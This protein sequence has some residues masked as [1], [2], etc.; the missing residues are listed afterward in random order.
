MTDRPRRKSDAARRANQVIRG[1]TMLIM[2]LLGVASF[3]VLF[4]KLYDLQI[5]RHDELKAEAVGQQTDSMVISASRGTIYDKN[6]EIMAI[7]YSTETVLLDPGGVQDFVESQ[8]QKIQDAAEEAAEKGAPYTAPE[9]LDQAYIARGL[10]RILDVEEETILEHLENTA[11]R[12]WEVKKKV[13][14]DVADEVRRFINGEIDDEGNQ[15]TTVDEDGNTVLISTGGRPT[16]LQGISLTP[17]TKRLYP[18]G[19]LAGNVIGFVNANNMGAYGLEASYDDVLSG[20]TGLTITP[21]N[22]NGTPL[23]FSGGEQMF[24]AENGSSLVLTL[25]T[26]VQYALEKGLES[27]LDKYD[28]ANGGTGIVM[29]VNTGGIVAMASYPNYDP[30]DFSTIY[31]EG[32]QAE[33]DAAL[34]EIQQNRSTYETEEAYNQALANARATIQFKQ[35][36]NKCYQDTYEPGST[37]KPI[38]LATALEEGVVNMNTTFTCTGS[39]HVEGWGKAINCSK[40]AGHGTQTLKVATG[41][42]CNPAFVTMGLK[43]GTEAY[44]RY[45]KSFGLMETTGIDLPAEA[46]GIFANEDSFNSNVV[47]LAAYSFGQTFNVTPLELIRAQAATING[48]Y[49]YTPYLVEQVLDDEG[50]ILSQH[51]TTAVRQVISEETSAKVRECLEWV[52][53]DGGGRNGQVTGYR[54]GGKTGTADKTGT[55]DVVVSFMCFAPADDPQYIMLLTM[56]TPSRTTGTAVFGGTMVAPVASQIMSEILPLLGVEPDY[57]AEE[58]VGADTTVPNVVGQTREAAEDRLADLGFTFRTVGDGDTV[59]DQTP[60][61]GAIV[62]GNASIILY[63]GQEKPDTPCTVPNVVGKSAS[64]ANKAIT[65]AGLIMKVTGTTT[66]SSGNVYAITQ[67]LPAGTEVAAGTVVTV[68]FGDN[69]V[70]D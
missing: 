49:L 47:S 21:T 62:P 64:E 23:L 42:S 28:A 1:R 15:L 44:Y 2:L 40:R 56:D 17:D 70:L 34:A 65:N 4:W 37:F 66:A 14:Q 16:R 13:D 58:L 5:N 3:T 27:M 8:E 50:N 6:G 68:Q 26:N 9:V 33:L 41:N 57:T 46:E 18:F 10:S 38:T 7:S 59:T 45:L 67:S 32:L 60:A 55:K 54:I 29:D 36:R 25:D 52:V 63:L 30:G 69:S 61:G 20:S 53:S 39:I 11:N 31:T 12:Y 35:W 22:V 51:E 48:G 24:D 19:S 43:I